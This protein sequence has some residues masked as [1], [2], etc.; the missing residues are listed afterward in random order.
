MRR[1]ASF[2]CY[3]NENGQ[4]LLRLTVLD[5]AETIEVEIPPDVAI[6]F[7]NHMLTAALDSKPEE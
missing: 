7:A 6:S 5:P 3:P 4:V 1:I 2:P